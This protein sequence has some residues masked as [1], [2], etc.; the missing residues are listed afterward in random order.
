MELLL[1][2]DLQSLQF[3]NGKYSIPGPDQA[4]SVGKVCTGGWEEAKQA[5]ICWPQFWPAWSPKVALSVVPQTYPNVGRY[6][7]CFD[8]TLFSCLNAIGNSH[9]L[10]FS[11]WNQW[12]P[13]SF[14]SMG[15]KLKTK[16]CTGANSWWVAKLT[17]PCSRLLLQEG[18]V[19]SLTSCFPQCSLF[20][21]PLKSVRRPD[22]LP[23][24]RPCNNGWSEAEATERNAHS[25]PTALCLEHSL[26]RGRTKIWCPT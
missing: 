17:P 5:F 2:Q 9:Q 13:I 7:P 4:F 10:S 11:L 1:L 25:A 15:E 26:G 21:L 6:L 12:D 20:C 22:Q 23:L 3:D 19:F 16:T 24:G 8:P 18:M 14:V